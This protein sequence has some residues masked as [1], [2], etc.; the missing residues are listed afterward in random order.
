MTLV[1]TTGNKCD[2]LRQDLE[3]CRLNWY[4]SL[5]RTPESLSVAERG[6]V[7][8]AKKVI[9]FRVKADSLADKQSSTDLVNKLA[10]GKNSS[11]PLRVTYTIED[12]NIIHDIH[13]RKW[14]EWF[15]E[16]FI[17]RSEV[18]EINRRV[19]T[20]LS[21]VLGTDE[22]KQ[23]ALKHIHTLA[24]TGVELSAASIYH[25]LFNTE[26]NL[27][28]ANRSSVANTSDI[29]G[30]L[31]IEVIHGDPTIVDA[32]TYLLD[33]GDL[34]VQ[35]KGYVEYRP[36]LHAFASLAEKAIECAD[37]KR[38]NKR[39]DEQFDS[40]VPVIEIPRCE[41]KAK[42]VLIYD[43]TPRRRKDVADLYKAFFHALFTHQ[44]ATGTLVVQVPKF[45]EGRN[46]LKAALDE[47]KNTKSLP[48]RRI[49]LVVQDS[50]VSDELRSSI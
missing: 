31:D 29:A 4:C 13:E 9:M 22:E 18:I 21:T 42:Q 16:L 1:L 32:D 45:I 3:V 27:T 17:N 12:R 11:V 36:Q 14:R 41:L 26:L 20:V 47:I 8:L 5:G 37:T 15:S 34:A 46:G 10:K 33:I 35:G 24:D 44:D 30:K 39:S 6:N 19:A 40:S 38:H 25:S 48:C 50:L 23:V 2:R 49:I 43:A 28:P 7:Y